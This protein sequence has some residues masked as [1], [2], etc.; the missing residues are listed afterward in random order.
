MTRVGHYSRVRAVYLYN[1]CTVLCSWCAVDFL[2]DDEG[3]DVSDDA[4]LDAYLEAHPDV[5]FEHDFAEG[6]LGG[7]WCDFCRDEIQSPT[8]HNCCDYVEPHDP[9]RV[10]RLMPVQEGMLCCRCYARLTLGYYLDTD[11]GESKWEAYVGQLDAMVRA[12]ATQLTLGQ[13]A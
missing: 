13:N 9:V 3:L 12:N 5:V 11:E 1:S 2:R 10:H 8:C 6:S 4:A 7:E